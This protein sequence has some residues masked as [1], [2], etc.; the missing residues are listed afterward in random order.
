MRNNEKWMSKILAFLPHHHFQLAQAKDQIVPLYVMQIASDYP[1]LAGLFVAGVF[2]AALSSLST[3][4]NSL[5]GVLMK[6]FVE[7][8]RSKPLTERQTAIGLRAVVVIFGL[9][10]MAMVKVVQKL[11]MVMQLST[12]VGSMT[13]GPL[14]G[15]FTV[16][17]TMPFVKT[18]VS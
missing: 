7:P 13:A 9:S 11:G 2:S 15:M 14:F 17:M 6:D 3:A 18:E 8:Y 4:L 5:S 10:S 12:T 16:G 1:G